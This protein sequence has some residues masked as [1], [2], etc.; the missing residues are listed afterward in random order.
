MAPARLR[1]EPGPDGCLTEEPCW[2]VRRTSRA[3]SRAS[4]TPRPG[5]R[6][7]VESSRTDMRSM[8]TTTRILVR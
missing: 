4:P 6:R 1:C 3:S 8:I 5:A 2:T 7:S